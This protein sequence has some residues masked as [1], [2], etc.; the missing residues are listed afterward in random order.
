MSQA[1][2]VSTR[3]PYGLQRVCRLWRVP[4]STLYHHQKAAEQP[5]QNPT[6]DRRRPGPR[7]ACSDRHLLN[8][9]RQVL[10]ERP[11][12][13]EGYRKVWALLRQEGLRVGHERVLRLMCSSQHLI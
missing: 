2:S 4:R 8:R 5:P 7:G 9:I 12:V 1:C 13:G 6:P 11:F 10:K 3:K